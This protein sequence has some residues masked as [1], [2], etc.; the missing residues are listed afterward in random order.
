VVVLGPATSETHSLHVALDIDPNG[1]GVI[2]ESN[3]YNN[4][5]TS[6]TMP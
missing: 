2:D 6:F 5:A 4:F 3:E 1:A